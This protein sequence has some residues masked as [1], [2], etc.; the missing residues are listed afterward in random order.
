MNCSEASLKK[1]KGVVQEGLKSHEIKMDE[2]EEVVILRSRHMEA[3]NQVRQIT[4]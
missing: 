1:G 3:C 4:G 2:K